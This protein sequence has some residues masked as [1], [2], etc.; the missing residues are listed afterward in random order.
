[1][2]NIL[3]GF[4]LESNFDSETLDSVVAHL[5]KLNDNDFLTAWKM[6]G[7]K[8]VNNA[9]EVHHRLKDRFVKVYSK[10]NI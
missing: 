3:N 6:I 8:C 5:S 2:S 1:M 10:Q 4:N 7:L 9:I